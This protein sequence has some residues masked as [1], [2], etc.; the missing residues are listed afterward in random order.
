MSGFFRRRNAPEL[1]ASLECVNHTVIF[2]GNSPEQILHKLRPDVLCLASDLGTGLGSSIAETE[3]VKSYGGRVAYLTLHP[4]CLSTPTIADI[5]KGSLR[6]HEEY[7]AETMPVPASLVDR[8]SGSK[9]LVVGDVM[10]DEYVSGSISRISPEA[11]VPILDV[12][13]RRFT[14]GGAANVA[15]NMASLS[16]IAF[17]SGLIGLDQPGITLRGRLREYGIQ[18]NALIESETAQ[19]TCKTRF[20][21]GQQQIVR[22]D[23]ESRRPLSDVERN[24]LLTQ[25]TRIIPHVDVCVLSDYAKGLLDERM[26]Q[27]I[28]QF[29]LVH[30]KPTIVDPKGS[31]FRKYQGCSLITPNLKEAGIA[32]GNEIKTEEDLEAAG[33]KLLE[34]LPG[35]SLSS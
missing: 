26:C 1:I 28:I 6:E 33:T 14:C 16:G 22:V 12:S 2:T 5:V 24:D 18:L 27:D 15:A 30:A 3:I 23:Q 31:N 13:A 4:A 19:T 21:A 35:T 17:V 20:V 7:P 32:T 25:I 10:L 34:M 11:P 29:C 9:A 8:F